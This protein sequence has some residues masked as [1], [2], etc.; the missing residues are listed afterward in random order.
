MVPVELGSK[1]AAGSVTE[2]S[3]QLC[4]SGGHKCLQTEWEH[5]VCQ[6]KCAWDFALYQKR[7]KEQGKSY[8]FWL[9][10]RK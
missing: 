2:I 6:G 3:K 4:R 5:L 8:A 1:K 10:P 7:R 9:E